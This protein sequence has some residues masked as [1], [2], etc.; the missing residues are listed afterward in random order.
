MANKMTEQAE[1]P[2][3]AFYFLLTFADSTDST[4]TAFQEISGISS[5]ME[6]QQV[7][8]GGDN[9]FLHRLPKPPE[10][11][12]VLMKRGLADVNSAL[13]KWCRQVF[14]QGQGS[15]ITPMTI[16]A[17]LLDSNGLTLSRWQ[18]SGAYPVRWQIEAINGSEV[19]IAQLEL[20]FAFMYQ[21]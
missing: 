16:N 6:T 11:N 12:N 10:Y 9:H 2:S 17:A 5:Q 3:P 14:E 1:Y 20:R 13:V 21:S 7:A 19:L 15:T 8:E 18:F 4:G